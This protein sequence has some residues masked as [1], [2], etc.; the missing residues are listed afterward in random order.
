MKSEILFNS[1]KDSILGSLGIPKSREA[2]MFEVHNLSA[3]ERETRAKPSLP[4]L[5]LGGMGEG[6]YLKQ[7]C[8][9]F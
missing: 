9:L 3:L 7:K 5:G 8:M 2:S 4:S 1:S 6:R